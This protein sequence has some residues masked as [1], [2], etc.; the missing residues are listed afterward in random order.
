VNDK[1]L[2]ASLRWGIP[3]WTVF[4]SFFIFLV[5]DYLSAN[6]DT[7]YQFLNTTF[8]ED[9]WQLVLAAVLIAGAGVPLGFVLYQVY[10]YIRWNSPV[11]KDGMLP[12]LIVG[13]EMELGDTV[14]D[15]EDEDICMGVDWRR[16]VLSTPYDHRGKWHYLSPLL[17]EACLALD[18]EG[19]LSERHSALFNRLHSLGASLL[20][21][22]VGFGG[23]L[24]AKWRLNQ[25]QLWWVVAAL[26][27]TFVTVLFVSLEDR[28]R[29]RWKGRRR[30]RL[31][32][33]SAEVFISAL[34]FLY[35]V[36]NPELNS[37]LPYEIP[38]I[39]CGIF[40]LV[41]GVSA[42]ESRE[43]EGILKLLIPF[44]GILVVVK[45]LGLLWVVSVY[46]KH[47]GLSNVDNLANWP[48]ILSILLLLCIFV[49][50]LKNRQNARAALT[51][52]EYY[53]LRRY[54]AK[55]EEQE[56]EREEKR[57]GGGWLLRAVLGLSRSLGLGL[58][59]VGAE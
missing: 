6:D 20:G 56:P 39:L 23:Y 14:C 52:L 57:E 49:A 5:S 9:M 48:V 3:G 27:I 44:L 31:L 51:S 18:P 32:C 47:R 11:S 13:R 15:L 1:N 26:V 35:A 54:L 53:C 17:A 37:L 2:E 29:R 10:F 45:R 28:A 12:P 19:A 43:F 50:F 38:A 4:I 58:P 25:A 36:L 55:V 24:L 40:V 8:S 59:N 7:M 21:L 34:A 33:H 30:A 42:K 41:W 22:A 46:V 16:R